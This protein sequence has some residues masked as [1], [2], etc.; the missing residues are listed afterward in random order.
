MLILKFKYKIDQV[1]KS[2][3][4]FRLIKCKVSTCKDNPSASLSTQPLH[5]IDNI[6]QEKQYNKDPFELLKG[7]LPN[8]RLSTW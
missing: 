1:K 8:E 4:L 2:E 7:V 5:F 3:R 6:A